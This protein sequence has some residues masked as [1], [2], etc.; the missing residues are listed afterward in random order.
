MDNI[1]LLADRV[2]VELN[3]IEKTNSGIILVKSPQPDP[4]DYKIGTVVAVG[5]GKMDG[6]IRHEIAIKNDDKVMFQYGSEIKIEGKS[7]ILIK[8]EDIVMIIT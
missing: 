3:T 2:L 7:Y 1:K 5:P 6:P 8:E 4:S